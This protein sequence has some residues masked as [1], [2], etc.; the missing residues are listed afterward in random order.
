MS[1]RIR[2]GATLTVL[3]AALLLVGCGGFRMLDKLRPADDISDIQTRY[4]RLVRWNEFGK[5]SE[6]VDPEL[7]E[8]YLRDARGLHG[9]RFTDYEVQWVDQGADGRSATAHVRY[10]GYS[11]GALI[12]LPEFDETQEWYFDVLSRRWLVRPDMQGLVAAYQKAAP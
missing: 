8:A 9:L 6:Y 11:T 10:R 7:R 1:Q 12:E 3:F 4:T 5:A 2:V